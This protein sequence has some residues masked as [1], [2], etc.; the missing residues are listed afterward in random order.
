MPQVDNQGIRIYYE[1]EGNGPPLV[2]RQGGVSS[3]QAWRQTGY[4]E[5]LKND[6]Q[7][8]L[9]DARGRGKSDKPHVS[10]AYTLQAHVSD[11]VA[12][13]DELKI[14]TSHYWG[15]SMGGWIGF[16]MAQHAPERLRSLII[17]AAHPYEDLSFAAFQGI[18]GSD[19]DA[20]IAALE[21]TLQERIRT[22]LRSHVLAN[23]LR[24]LAAS[25]QV[26]SSMEAILPEMRMPCMLYV[27]EADTRC[28]AVKS[29]AGRIAQ[30]TVVTLPGLNHREAMLRSDLVLPHVR[31]FL[32]NLVER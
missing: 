9:I 8:V 30:A 24:A 23:D 15:Y 5:R 31:R 6:F 7:C 17:G 4:V 32:A 22:E 18:D 25:M 2:L 19:P 10:S 28:S 12:V 3:L 13:I 20:F 27:G 16:G 21:A 11:V 14:Q 29:C 26:R 1:V